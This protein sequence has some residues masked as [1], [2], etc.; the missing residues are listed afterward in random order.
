M[1]IPSNDQIKASTLNF[2][3]EGEEIEAAKIFASCKLEFNVYD[4]DFG[5]YY[6]IIDLYCP[7]RAYDILENEEDNLNLD[8]RRSLEAVTPTEFALSGINVTAEMID[9]LEI[10]EQNK[11]KSLTI[12]KEVWNYVEKL[13]L[14]CYKS[15]EKFTEFLSKHEI[16]YYSRFYPLNRKGKDYRKFYEYMKTENNDFANF[17]AEEV[18]SYKYL[19]VL[20]EIIFDEDIRKT[21]GDNWNYLSKPIKNWYPS[22]ISFS[23][24][25]GLNIDF[26]EKKLVYEIKKDE[27]FV[28]NNFE[29]SF[30]DIVHKRI[31]KV[32]KNKFED[33]YY[34]DAVESAFKEVNV[35]VKKIVY[36]KI[37]EER[38][39]T[40]LMNKAFGFSNS[41]DPIIKLE[42]ISNRT[43]KNIQ[44]GYK[45]IF[46]GSM[47]GIR[48]PKA[49]ENIEISKEE[50][51]HLLL[52]ASQLM[53]KLDNADY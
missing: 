18:A 52:L 22:L 5:G 4:N 39:G 48:N 3:I 17:M 40:T 21:E 26:K 29:S 28:I 38:D 45:E 23:K 10:I 27:Y 46:S 20:E 34:A 35:R 31:V 53:Y 49:H 16:E 14:H 51:I 37:G 36:D 30:W 33:L 42:D 24:K 41:C 7:R 11:F 19:N 44:T 9:N 32:S 6:S 2:L 1:E 15:S 25:A 43:G 8:I 13:Y 47:L 12:N 50:G